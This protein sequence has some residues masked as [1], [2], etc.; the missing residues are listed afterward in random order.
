MEHENLGL[1]PQGSWE[2]VRIGSMHLYL[3]VMASELWSLVK[4]PSTSCLLCFP[5]SLG[6]H[7]ETEVGTG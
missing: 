7:V 4:G 5:G 2:N 6:H 1:T 3:G